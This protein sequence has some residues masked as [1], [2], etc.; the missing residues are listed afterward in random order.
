VL[1]WYRESF[2]AERLV[3][4]VVA[5]ALLLRAA[6]E[7]RLGQ[8]VSRLQPDRSA[9][10][11]LIDGVH[12]LQRVPRRLAGGV[13]LPPS[14]LYAICR[15][16]ATEG[17]LAVLAASESAAP[18]R[19]LRSY[20][21]ELREVRPEIRGSDLL[22]AGVI[23]GPAVARGLD[24]ALRARLDGRALDRSAQLEVALR[25]AGRP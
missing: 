21:T 25:A 20:L 17:L 6:D 7:R 14:R 13:R 3:S 16:H 12:A 8:V 9:R 10:R 5:L 24:A 4:W 18:R 15:P 23:P 2:P 19:A 11:L 1:S 22:R